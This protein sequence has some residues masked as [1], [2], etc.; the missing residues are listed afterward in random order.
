[1]KIIWFQFHKWKTSSSMH[2]DKTSNVELSFTYLIVWVTVFRFSD[3]ADK[4]RSLL[5]GHGVVLIFIYTLAVCQVLE[6]IMFWTIKCYCDSWAECLYYITDCSK[7]TVLVAR[8]YILWIT[9]LVLSFT[10]LSFAY[11]FPPKL[12]KEKLL[13]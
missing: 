7:S 12:L 2:Q 5:L 3:G 1:M 8:V 10:S 11:T 9:F 4:S 6:N 13:T